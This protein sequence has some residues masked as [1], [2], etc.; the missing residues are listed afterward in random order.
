MYK[1]NYIPKNKIIIEPNMVSSSIIEINGEKSTLP[2]FDLDKCT[3]N[4]LGK[5]YLLE[6][7]IED[8][9]TRGE[10]FVD[11]FLMGD[12]KIITWFGGALMAGH[13]DNLLFLPTVNKMVIENKKTTEV[14]IPKEIRKYVENRK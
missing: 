9:S 2:I 13:K 7:K 4:S 3:I 11:A 12:K 8:E 14:T 1:N 6:G 10:G 5:K